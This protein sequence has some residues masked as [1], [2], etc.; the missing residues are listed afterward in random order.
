METMVDSSRNESGM[1]GTG[2]TEGWKKAKEL[3]VPEENVASE[4]TFVVRENTAAD[5]TQSRV[6]LKQDP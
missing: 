4:S 3:S 2:I 6:P 1:A 5:G